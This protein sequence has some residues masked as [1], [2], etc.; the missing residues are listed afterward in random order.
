MRWGYSFGLFTRRRGG[1]SP[2][3]ELDAVQDFLLDQLQVT[4][5]RMF[6][7]HHQQCIIQ[8]L[9]NL[10]EPFRVLRLMESDNV[11]QGIEAY[12]PCFLSRFK[13]T[14]LGV[15]DG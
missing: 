11:V 12:I 14:E 13:V 3:C 6:P 4:F 8:P 10:I 1:G 2:Y 15:R 7:R 5:G 9:D